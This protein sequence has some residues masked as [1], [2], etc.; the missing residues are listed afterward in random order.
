VE[1]AIWRPIAECG[2]LVVKLEY[3]DQSAIFANTSVQSDATRVR[4]GG[5]IAVKKNLVDNPILPSTA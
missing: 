4:A 1:A 2:G 3:L 5:A